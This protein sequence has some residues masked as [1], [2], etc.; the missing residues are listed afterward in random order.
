MEKL[1]NYLKRIGVNESHRH[2][3]PETESAVNFYRE[4]FGEE[5]YF[6]NAPGFTYTGALVTFEYNAEA[7]AEYFRELSKIEERIKKY[8]RRYNY[9]Y[10]SSLG[11]GAR[12]LTICTAADRER[13]DN[14]YFF[15]DASIR[16]FETMQHQNHQNGTPEKIS[17]EARKIMDHYGTLYNQF[18]EEKTA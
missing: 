16:D 6:F 18:L 10:I 2:A 4:S 11:Y 17:S 15:R 12:Y 13:A 7:P 14:Y 1:F 5:K 8:C 3:R 9:F